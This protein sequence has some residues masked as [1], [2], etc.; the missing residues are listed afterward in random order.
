[1]SSQQRKLAIQ[2]LLR[3]GQ[4]KQLSEKLNMSYSYLSQ[5][6]SPGTAISFTADLARKVEH[7][8]ALEEGQ[9]DQGNNAVIQKHPP[10]ALQALVLRTRAIDLKNYLNDKRVE[11]EVQVEMAGVTKSADLGVYNQNNSVYII[12]E[13]CDNYDSK[14]AA[15]KIILLMALSGAEYG[16]LFAPESGVDQDSLKMVDFTFPPEHR[17]SKWYQSENGKI[18]EVAT[19]PRGLYEHVGI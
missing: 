6:F 17:L 7:A 15:D 12:A 11:L 13:Q 9:L 2:A 4:L 16:V 5:A 18:S 19:G 8:L 1:M 10:T 3:R 14:S